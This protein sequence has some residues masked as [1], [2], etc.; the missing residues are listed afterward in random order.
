MRV[1]YR[2]DAVKLSHKVLTVCQ[3]CDREYTH[4]LQKSLYNNGFHNMQ[5]S[6]SQ[7]YEWAE[8]EGERI[9]KEGAICTT[10]KRVGAKPIPGWT[11][12]PFTPKKPQ[13]PYEPIA[14]LYLSPGAGI[15]WLCS[16][17]EKLNRLVC[18]ETG[19]PLIQIPYSP[20]NPGTSVK[21]PFPAE[22]VSD[23]QTA[24]K[25]ALA[26]YKEEFEQY[27]KDIAVYKLIKQQRQEAFSNSSISM[28][29]NV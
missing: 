25:L 4:N 22:C 27:K 16:K 12:P 15:L 19:E 1:T 8:K 17:G 9:S 11:M 10:C 21:K 20:E 14:K 18:P 28:T 7:W 2:F 24:Y 29:A 6:K 13:K 3:C 26:E 23:A 5:E